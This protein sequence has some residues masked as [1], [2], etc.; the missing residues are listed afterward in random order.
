MNRLY[1]YFTLGEV[2]SSYSPNTSTD[3][4]DITSL[5]TTYGFVIEDSS[6]DT[7]LLMKQVVR[8]VFARFY[9]YYVLRKPVGWLQQVDDVVVES[10][11]IK[12]IVRAIVVDFNNSAPRFIPLLKSY[13]NNQ[14]NPIGKVS[15]TTTGSTRFNDTP[16]DSGDYSDDTH[17]TNITQ[18]TATTE[19]DSG[20]IMDRLDALYRNW[21]SILLDW[22]E[23]FK[24]I[25]YCAE[26][27]K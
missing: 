20:S 23:E 6:A 7:L 12:N 13:K 9:E 2:F 18:S 26:W 15:S 3:D 27:S 16:Q 11:D 25:F 10:D 24:G 14:A 8:M 5:M 22:T 21:R 4:I 1:K 19:A 17:T